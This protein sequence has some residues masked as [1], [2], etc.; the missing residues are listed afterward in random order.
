MVGQ[1]KEARPEQ[2]ELTEQSQQWITF[3]KEKS[4]QSLIDSCSIR[5]FIPSVYTACLLFYF[6]SRTVKASRVFGPVFMYSCWDSEPFLQ[7]SCIILNGR[8][9]VVLHTVIPRTWKKVIQRGEVYL[10]IDDMPLFSTSRPF[11]K[12][13][14]SVTW[15]ATC[16]LKRYKLQQ[17]RLLLCCWKNS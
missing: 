2:M 17:L 4:P 16:R 11:Q 15:A 8:C 3:R 9:G 14:N 6:H 1:H 12:E 10:L 13:A 5:V 7:L